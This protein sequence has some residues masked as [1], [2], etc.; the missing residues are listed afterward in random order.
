MKPT[1]EDRVCEC[2]NDVTF[3]IKSLVQL[4]ITDRLAFHQGLELSSVYGSPFG[5]LLRTCDYNLAPPA[6]VA[7]V[8]K[9]K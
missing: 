2:L 9:I 4:Q 3:L 8:S 5:L 6:L 1:E 7:A